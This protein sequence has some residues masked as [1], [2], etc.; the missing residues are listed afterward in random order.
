MEMMFEGDDIETAWR[1]E[2]DEEY[3]RIEGGWK[4]DR[5]K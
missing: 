2:D 4:N 5:Q 1:V 3:Y